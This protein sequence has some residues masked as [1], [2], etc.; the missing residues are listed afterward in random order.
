VTF[1]LE[2][3]ALPL[4]AEEFARLPPVPGA[5]LEL[6]EGSLVVAAAAQRAWHSEAADRVRA[7]F[8]RRGQRAIREVG[9][10]IGPSAV[11]VPDV[12]VF[13]AGAVIDQD[14]SQFPAADVACVAEIVSPESR[15]RDL[16]E[17]P[18]KYA[19]AGIP[20]Y[21]IVDQESGK[22]IVRQYG[23]TPTTEGDQYTLIRSVA[24]GDLEAE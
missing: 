13:R 22:I 7:Y 19:R 11:P 6:W 14:K 10:V 20:E 24:L 18:P 21:W 2:L 4:T 9:V 15:D 5:R 12:T 1:L 17:K 23:L 3:P 16:A 8:T